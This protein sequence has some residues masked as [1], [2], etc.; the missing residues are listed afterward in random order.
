MTCLAVVREGKR[1]YFAGD[2][3]V[4]WGFHKAQIM[5]TP[6][7]SFINGVLRAGTGTGS[8][9]TE[10]VD[11]Y[12]GPKAPTKGDLD[13]FML[14]P[15]L[16]DVI[17]FLTKKL[18]IPKGTRRL[19]AAREGSDET[20]ASILLGVKDRLYEL[21]LGSDGV[22]MDRIAAPYAS[23]C[24]GQLALGALLALEGQNLPPEERLK[25]ALRIAAQVSPG[26]DSNIDIIHN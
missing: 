10:M 23:G 18:Y 17:K 3:R 5:E 24:G 7:I 15:F 14:G 6:K 21:D 11:L 20:G 13:Q 1:L 22:S 16:E 25:A 19:R 8:L 4:S 2:R 12:K 9:C 26:C